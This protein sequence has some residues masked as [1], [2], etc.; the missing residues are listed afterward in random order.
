[1]ATIHH[2]P[3]AHSQTDLNDYCGCM[4]VHAAW[5]KSSDVEKR[6]FHGCLAHAAERPRQ[7]VCTAMARSI[8]IRRCLDADGAG[9]EIERYL[10]LLHRSSAHVDLPWIVDCGGGGTPGDAD[11]KALLDGASQSAGHGRCWQSLMIFAKGADDRSDLVMSRM[12]SWP[13]LPHLAAFCFL[14]PDGDG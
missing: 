3:L 2:F 4:F 8:A 10:G 14:L 13:W 11:L 9:L 12:I 7:L 1:M 6:I 5:I